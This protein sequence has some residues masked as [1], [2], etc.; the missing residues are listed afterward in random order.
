MQYYRR[1]PRFDYLS[2]NT[3]EEAV[4]L[5]GIY[6]EK[7]KIYAG[8]TIVLHRMKKRVQ[9]KPYLIGLKA[10]PELDN[11][12]VDS[13]SWL[14]IGSMVRHEDIAESKDVKRF[15]PLL[16]LV[17]SQLGTPQIRNMGTIGGNI[18]SMFSTA[19]TL[20]VLIALGAQ[21]NIVSSNGERVILIE[22][23]YKNLREG[24]IITQINVPIL[25]SNAKIGYKKFALRE[26]FDYATVSAAV[27]MQIEEDKCRDIR[28]GIGGVTLPTMR[29]RIAEE[30]MYGKPLTDE[31]ID[32]VSKVAAEYGKTGSEMIFS[33]DYKK[34]VLKV[35]VKRA[36]LD[37][38]KEVYQ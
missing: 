35:M 1:L 31:L 22:D 30:A 13:P 24:G 19:E 26:R 18:A 4:S 37:A 33:S 2:P 32:K 5:I 3:I 27:I 17:C 34:Q 20:P 38:I 36:M 12:K 14:K 10:I 29:P 15:C 6:K 16:S 28:I 11:I 25:P 9:V 8:G 21:V 23:T 7:A